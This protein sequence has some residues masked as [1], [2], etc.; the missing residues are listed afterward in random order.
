MKTLGCESIVEKT[1]ISIPYGLVASIVDT[2]GKKKRSLEGVV[3]VYQIAKFWK[4]MGRRLSG[5]EK[6]RY[7]SLKSNQGACKGDKI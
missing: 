4:Q 2:E 7:V 3:F 5:E 1:Q 6:R